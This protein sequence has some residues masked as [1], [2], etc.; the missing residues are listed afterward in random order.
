MVERL[1]NAFYWCATLVALLLAG[2]ALWTMTL[3]ATQGL[4]DYPFKGWRLPWQP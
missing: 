4:A 3:P 1:A 2:L